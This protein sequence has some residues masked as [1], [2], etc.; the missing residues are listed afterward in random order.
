MN[1]SSPSAN[2]TIARATA[3]ATIIDNDA[4]P[5]PP[6]VSIG[7][8]VVDEPDGTANFVITLDR[9][10]ASVVS[11]DYATQ[12]GAPITGAS[13]AQ[14]GSDYVKTSGTLKFVPGE[15]AKTVKVQ[16]TNDNLPE[17]AE[18]FSLALVWTLPARP[19]SIPSARR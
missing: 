15:T 6:Q 3:T 7:D 14:A 5:G 17:G 8:L 12:D 13:A 2:A 19:R 11:I 4:P 10:S 9:P 18:A 16:L 1:L